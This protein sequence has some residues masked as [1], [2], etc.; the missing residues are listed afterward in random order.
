MISFVAH[1]PSA[2]FTKGYGQFLW[3]VSKQGADRRAIDPR[4]GK[5]TQGA[6]MALELL[7][8]RVQTIENEEA[9]IAEIEADIAAKDTQKQGHVN[10]IEGYRID[11][12]RLDL[13]R[14]ALE[15]EFTDAFDEMDSVQLQLDEIDDP[16]SSGS[17]LL[18][19]QRDLKRRLRELKRKVE[20][21]LPQKLRGI[22]DES[23]YL[24]GRINSEHRAINNLNREI[25][26]L[27]QDLEEAAGI[28]GD[29]LRELGRQV[30]HLP[31]GDLELD[32]DLLGIY[33]R[34]PHILGDPPL[35]Y[36]DVPG[37]P[38]LH[39]PIP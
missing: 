36:P 21:D 10:T 18:T 23:E 26:V 17:G 28:L 13:E 29:T 16:L 31:T 24:D 1:L 8:G 11:L 25:E 37:D 6:S 32:A 33:D 39:D 38:P 4:T 19:K 34:Y 12:A 27:E 30:K 9:T 7:K 14:D 35:H 15:A 5:P 3:E 2:I 20:V 22:N